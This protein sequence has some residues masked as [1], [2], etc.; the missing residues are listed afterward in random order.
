MDT[1]III[2]VVILFIRYVIKKRNRFESLR[3]SVRH[4][5]L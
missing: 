2:V 4:G 3:R 1:L 5:A